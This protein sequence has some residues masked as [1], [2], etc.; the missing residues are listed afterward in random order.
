[1]CAD[2]INR[3]VIFK[4]PRF[5]GDHVG[6]YHR[7]FDETS[8]FGLRS[9]F[10]AFGLGK[11]PGVWRIEELMVKSKNLTELVYERPGYQAR[12]FHR[13]ATTLFLEETQKYD[14]SA[15]QYGILTVVHSRPGIDQIGACEV[16][17]ADRS[18]LATV[19]DRLEKQGLVER[20]ASATDRRSNALHLTLLGKRLLP[21]IRR[22]EERMRKRIFK[23]L[24]SPELEIFTELMTRI[25]QDH[26][27]Y[28][29]LSEATSRVKRREHKRL[30]SMPTRPVA[31]VI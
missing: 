24:S 18:T 19:V 14:V 12:Q 9:G 2:T 6:A 4:A 16:L 21:E 22:A 20:V 10:F 23:S 26:A 13:I 28:A 1:M 7:L 27:Q 25:I 17:G 11:E 31:E 3:V 29:R 15:L 5:R 30:G 8:R